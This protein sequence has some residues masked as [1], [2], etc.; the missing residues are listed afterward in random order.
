MA[1][2]PIA[3][4]RL[5]AE[6]LRDARIENARLEAELLLG[7]VLGLRRLD[8]YLQHDRPLKPDEVEI[9]RAHV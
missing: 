3:L 2:T 9:G 7:A 6:R 5:A 4:T 8:L 1:Q